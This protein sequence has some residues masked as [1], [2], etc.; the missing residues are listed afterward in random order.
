M[1]RTEK[2]KAEDRH[3]DSWFREGKDGR[4]TRIHR[5]GRRALFTPVKVAGG[6]NAKM[7][8]KKIR[9]TRGKYFA[10]GRTLKIIDDW[11]TR[12]N[13]HRLLD[14]SW[15]GAIDF[16][17]VAEYIDDDS[18]E[19]ID[20]RELGES[21][22]Q[23]FTEVPCLGPGEL[24]VTPKE[25]AE[26]AEELVEAPRLTGK[27]VEPQKTEYYNLS[28]QKDAKAQPLE[29]LARKFRRVPPAALLSLHGRS[30]ALRSLSAALPSVTLRWHVPE[31]EYKRKSLSFDRPACR[32]PMVRWDDREQRTRTLRPLPL[33]SC[34]G[35]KR[36][37]V[38]FC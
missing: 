2:E 34:Q 1:F 16:R 3:V 25:K 36:R 21:L 6:P 13:A 11:T 8:L 35:E 7:P 37:A 26:T 24:K 15:I 23:P 12:A 14:G 10:S 33:S 32:P 27:P 5:S 29:T 17:E 19:E 18:D 30:G 22:A 31:G 9:I 4:W 28:P 20:A 38:C